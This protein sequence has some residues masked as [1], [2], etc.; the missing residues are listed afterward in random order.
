M[1]APCVPCCVLAGGCPS[2]AAA[3]PHHSILLVPAIKPTSTWTALLDAQ[4]GLSTQGLF[5]I[6]AACSHDVTILQG[7]VVSFSTFY[8]TLDK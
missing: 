5:I 6:L 2:E 3:L 1:W 7:P 4:P 8:V